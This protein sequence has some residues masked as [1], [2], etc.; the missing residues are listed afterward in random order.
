MPLDARS[1]GLEG[2]LQ[3]RRRGRGG[4][5]CLQ[6]GA[7]A[8]SPLCSPRAGLGSPSRGLRPSRLAP[9]PPPHRAGVSVFPTTEALPLREP[10]PWTRPLGSPSS[11]NRS[12]LGGGGWQAGR[13]AGGK[14]SPITAPAPH[15]ARGCGCHFQAGGGGPSREYAWEASGG[16]AR[17]PAQR[18]PRGPVCARALGGRVGSAGSSAAAAH[19]RQLEL[20]KGALLKNPNQTWRWSPASAG[21]GAETTGPAPRRVHVP[22]PCGA[23]DAPGPAC[24]APETR[25]SWTVSPRKCPASTDYPAGAVVPRP[26]HRHHGQKRSVSP[27]PGAGWSRAGRRPGPRP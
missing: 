2:R 15:P 10:P 19:Q 21:A 18:G 1:P 9:A 11:P 12:E 24:G 8:G 13:A 17:A 6:V 4:G 16:G 7:R 23:L 22:A 3:D 5:L 20:T 14:G 27:T 26:L 25:A